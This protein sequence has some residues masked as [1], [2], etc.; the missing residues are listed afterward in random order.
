LAAFILIDGKEVLPAHNYK[1]EQWA[2]FGMQQTGVTL[3]Q[4]FTEK[5]L[6]GILPS[7]NPWIGISHHSTHISQRAYY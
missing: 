1:S 3:L 6:K 7:G 2:C 4:F 5:A